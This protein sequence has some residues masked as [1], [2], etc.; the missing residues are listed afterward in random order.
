MSESGRVIV[1]GGGCAG[2]GAA[3]RLAEAGREVV[4]LETRPR[5]G[6]R[7]TSH[8]DQPTGG[9]IDNC[10][11]VVLGCC[12]NLIDLYERIGVSD[13]VEWHDALWFADREERVWRFAADPLP[14]PLHLTRAMLGYKGLSLK[15]R[16]GVAL[17]MRKI[18]RAWG[19]GDWEGVTFGQWLRGAGQ[20][21]RAI[22]RFWNLIVVSAC[23]VTVDEAAAR[24]AMQVFA[25]G[26]MAHRRGYVM[27]VSRVP[28]VDLYDGVARI[29]ERA[30]G[31][32]RTGAGVEAIVYEGGS[33]RGVRTSGGEEIEGDWVISALP[34]DRL[35][36]VAGEALVQA[37]ARLQRL[38]EIGVSP[39]V[40]IHLWVDRVV[41]DKPHV[42]FTDAVVDW[43]F[44]KGGADGGQHLHAGISAADA[45]VGMGEDEIVARCWDALKGYGHVLGGVDRA[46]LVRGRVIKERRAT[47]AAGVGIDALRPRATGVVRNLLLAGDWVN[48]GWPATMEGAVR[49]GYV[50]AGEVL[51]ERVL[52]DDLS[53]AGLSRLIGVR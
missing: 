28:L 21:E 20:S 51:G 8:V 11:H 5:L 29:I 13:Q 43:V 31:V 17:A 37:D 7:A 15:D 22:E 39:I 40:G 19:K 38:G 36:K 41:C 42:F 3:V 12:T 44:A 30:G 53:V 34:S 16:V 26:F 35:A 10:Q 50:A 4:L 24:Y 2:I 45:W 23:N 9:K 33:V 49:S 48:T 14:A 18:A 46:K 52:V 27:G 6:G 1:L 47:F 32:V 25:Q